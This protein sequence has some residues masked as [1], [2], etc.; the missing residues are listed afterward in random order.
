MGGDTDRYAPSTPPRTT[1]QWM[2]DR[3]C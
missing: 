1:Y 2:L 3:T